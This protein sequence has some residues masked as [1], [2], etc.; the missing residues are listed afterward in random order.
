MVWGT[1][2]ALIVLLVFT[3]SSIDWSKVHFGPEKVPFS[4]LCANKEKYF[5]WKSFSFENGT[6]IYYNE[7][8]GIKFAVIVPLPIPEDL[9]EDTYIAAKVPTS[10]K[11]G[12]KVNIEGAI[13]KAEHEGK[14]IYYLDGYKLIKTGAIDTNDPDFQSLMIAVREKERQEDWFLWWFIFWWFYWNPA[15]PIS[16]F[17]PNYP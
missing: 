4:D 16:P 5:V 11:V 1:I 14:S 15:S 3:I 12:D 10:L 2:L 6:V 17:N 8:K 9:R 13:K 7:T